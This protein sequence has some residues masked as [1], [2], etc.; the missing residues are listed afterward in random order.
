LLH[1][2]PNTHQ[3]QQQQQQSTPT[4]PNKMLDDDTA[5]AVVSVCW[6]W[7]VLCSVVTSEPEAKE[8]LIML[9]I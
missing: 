1:S 6:D 4:N 5:A 9:V 2:H 3:Q 8:L 7:L